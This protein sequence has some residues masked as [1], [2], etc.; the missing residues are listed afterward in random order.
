[1]VRTTTTILPPPSDYPVPMPE[2]PEAVPDSDPWR[3]LVE[4]TRDTVR[5]GA[6]S[7][8]SLEDLF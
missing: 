2:L 6:P 1:M 8:L 4:L 3:Q 7:F 5:P